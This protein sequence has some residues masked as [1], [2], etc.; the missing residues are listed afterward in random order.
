M[1]SDRQADQIALVWLSAAISPAVTVLILGR[2]RYRG[3]T[4]GRQKLDRRVRLGTD[5]RSNTQLGRVPMSG[6]LRIGFLQNTPERMIGAL[7]GITSG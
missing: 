3:R 2:Y 7:T 4:F 5:Y 6:R 1:L